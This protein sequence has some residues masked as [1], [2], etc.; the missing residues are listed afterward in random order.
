[1]TDQE[2]IKVLREELRNLMAAVQEG[3]TTRG[4]I[5][6]DEEDSWYQDALDGAEST[7]RATE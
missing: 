1:M 3:L 4:D 5:Q 7:L 2:K 6:V